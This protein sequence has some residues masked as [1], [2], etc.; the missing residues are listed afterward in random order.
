MV[1]ADRP[2]LSQPDSTAQF[3][4]EAREIEQALA[5]FNPRGDV[6]EIASGTG[7]WTRFLARTAGSLTC[8]DTSPETI[9]LNR[10]RL[11]AE[12]LPE[13]RYIEAD[14]F[15]WEPQ[16]R[17]DVVAFSFWISHVPAARFDAFWAK[18][19]R[20]LK[21]GGRVFFVDEAWAEA[22]HYTATDEEGRQPRILNDGRKF[23]IIKIYYSPEDIAARLSA[24]GWLVEASRTATQFLYG[25]ARRDD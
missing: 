8:I 18:V 2:P 4:A 11:A 23:T 6:L 21:P 16:A 12:G 5:R 17:Y 3:A 22:P 13:A 10:A 24:L 19:A 15:A 25:Q 20:C 9:A 14:I 7:W 1:A